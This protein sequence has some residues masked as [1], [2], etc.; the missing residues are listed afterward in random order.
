M[1]SNPALPPRRPPDLH[2]AA[3]A[4]GASET[5]PLKVETMIATFSKTKCALL[6]RPGYPI[7]TP[8]PLYIECICGRDL[9][10]PGHGD[11]RCEV[12]GREYNPDG[13]VLDT[14]A[15]ELLEACRAAA[16]FFRDTD[17][18]RE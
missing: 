13:W 5:T 1:R 3:E 8:A 2:P 16:D 7:G 12:C 11:I 4:G 14:A 9:D 10:A 15:P 6:R 17:A 18:P